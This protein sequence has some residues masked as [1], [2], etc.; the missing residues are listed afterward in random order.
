M[1]SPAGPGLP[2]ALTPCSLGPMPSTPATT[3]QVSY[4]LVLSPFYRG[5]HE[6]QRGRVSCQKPPS[7][8]VVDLG[9]TLKNCRSQPV[10]LATT[11]S[12]QMGD[13]GAKSSVRLG[14]GE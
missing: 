6:A 5:R 10:L 2:G 3:S 12:L 7:Q 8:P 13:K 4:V 9:F 11:L 14:R 1:F